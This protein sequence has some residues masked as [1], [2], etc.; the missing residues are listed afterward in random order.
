MSDEI[1]RPVRRIRKL[2]PLEQVDAL[3]KEKEPTVVEPQ[4]ANNSRDFSRVSNQNVQVHQIETRNETTEDYSSESYRLRKLIERELANKNVSNMIGVFGNNSDEV[5]R[6][7]FE[8]VKTYYPMIGSFRSSELI[9]NNI[10]LLIGAGAKQYSDRKFRLGGY[11]VWQQLVL[12]PKFAMIA[13][14]PGYEDTFGYSRLCRINDVHSRNIECGNLL[15]CMRKI[16]EIPDD[17]KFVFHI[18]FDCEHF[19]REILETFR[20]INTPD[21]LLIVSSISSVEM[22]SAVLNRTYRE[23]G[24]KDSLLDRYFSFNNMVICKGEG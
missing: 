14:N 9:D 2:S 23:Y 15:G 13:Q 8:G 10:Y 16:F 5:L 7:A 6:K 19:T 18:D 22:N 1:Y 3:N 12:N 21:L 24:M 4:I 11:P 17:T 20:N